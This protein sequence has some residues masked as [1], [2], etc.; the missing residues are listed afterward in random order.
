MQTNYEEILVELKRQN[1]AIERLNVVH[2]PPQVDP[3]D[4]WPEERLPLDTFK[5]QA[6]F[7]ELMDKSEIAKSLMVIVIY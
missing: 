1:T 5:D 2:P 3:D 4:E 7:E 6:E